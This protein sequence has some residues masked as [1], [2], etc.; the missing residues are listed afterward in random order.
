ML[1]RGKCSNCTVGMGSN[2]IPFIKF[3][4]ALAVMLF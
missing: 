4:L 1:T 2:D 3:L